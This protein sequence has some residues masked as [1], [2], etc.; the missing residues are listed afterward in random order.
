M[1]QQDPYALPCALIYCVH[2]PSSITSELAVA[3]AATTSNVARTSGYHPWQQS[4]TPAHCQRGSTGTVAASHAAFTPGCRSR[5]Q[6]ATPAVR[7]RNPPAR[8]RR[9]APPARFADQHGSGGHAGAQPAQPH[10]AAAMPA[11]P[12]CSA[13][14][15]GSSGHTRT[16]QAQPHSTAA[17]PRDARLLSCCPT[18]QQRLHQHP[19]GK[20]S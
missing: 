19:A 15:H 2:T 16:P 9:H 5:Q 18:R 20:A 7:Q 4:A 14:Q 12:A 1:A 3:N 11:P 6:P 10:R 8:P 13:A 17:A